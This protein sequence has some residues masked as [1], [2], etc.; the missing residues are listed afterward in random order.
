MKRLIEHIM[1]ASICAFLV[2]I[3][4]VFFR[5]PFSEVIVTMLLTLA[6]VLIMLEVGDDDVS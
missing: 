4:A 6:I 5:R 1:T 2:F 3:F